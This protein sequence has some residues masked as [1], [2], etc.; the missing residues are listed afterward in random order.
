[1][2]EEGVEQIPL[3]PFV[4]AQSPILNLSL[5]EIVVQNK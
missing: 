1:M 3:V 5:D 4:I 2:E